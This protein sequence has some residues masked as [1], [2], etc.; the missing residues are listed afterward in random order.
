MPIMA[1]PVTIW[2]AVGAI[3]AAV[4]GLGSYLGWWEV[5]RQRPK[6]EPPPEGAHDGVLG[7]TGARDGHSDSVDERY[8]AYLLATYQYLDFKGILQLERLP[9]RLPLERVYVRLHAD[10]TLSTE[11]S[12]DPTYVAGRA[13]EK[14]ELANLLSENVARKGEAIHRASIDELLSA[15]RSIVLLGDPGSGKS[16]VLKYLALTAARHRPIGT[17]LDE[18]F[19]P[20][21]VPVAA[22]AAAIR[23][24]R[25]VPFDQYCSDYYRDVRGLPY[26]L[27]P[28]FKTAL[29]DGRALVLIDG[30]DEV[31][32]PDQRLFVV[33]RIEDFYNLHRNR[34]NRFVV[35]SR[36]LGYRDAPLSAAGVAHF[37]LGDFSRQDIEQFARNWCTAFETAIRGDTAAVKEA[38]GD[39]AAALLR[40]VVANPNVER[41]AANPLL[42]TILALI[43]RQGMELPR[44]RV[45]LYELYLKTLI[46][47]WAR[48][49]NLDGRPIGPMD[50]VEAV[51]LLAPVAYWMHET[52]PSG[53]A[54]SD[55]LIARIGGYFEEKRHRTPDDAE[56]MARQFIEDVKRYTGVLTERGQNAYG[57][58]HLTFEEYLAAREITFCGQV[59]KEKAV[60]L[61]REH[62][63][64]P[65]W[66]EV[67]R[68]AV[69]YTSIIAKEERAAGM[70]VE[71]L[72]KSGG[73]S[74]GVQNVLVAGECVRDAQI[75][76]V[77]AES[78][79]AVAKEL[80]GLVSDAGVDVRARHR[81]G[82]ILG[83]IED[84]RF[85]DHE[86]VPECVAISDMSFVM[87]TEAAS[88]DAFISEVSKVELA[89]EFDWVRHYW[90]VCLKSE[91]PQHEGRVAAFRMSRFPITHAQY[92]CFINETPGYEVPHSESER[93]KSY[94]WDKKTRA[95][96][97][98]RS[99]HP[100][101]LISWIDAAAYC[102]WL[103][104]VSGRR[105]RL[106]T[107]AEWEAAARGG[108]R[109]LY[110]WGDQ[111]IPTR[112]NTAESGANGT[113]ASGCY[114]DAVSPCGIWDC[115]GQVW[116]WTSTIWGKSWEDEEFKYPYVRDEREGTAGSHWRV[117]RGGSWD[118]VAV[119][120]RCAARGPNT[121]TF[122]SHYLGFRIVQEV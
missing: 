33:S 39:E 55:E 36:I 101:V 104:A 37:A 19:V 12:S 107:E 4:T 84:T 98:G 71:G 34:G 79:A 30:L 31:T 7:L 80:V 117:V 57:F 114:P 27:A 23:D 9:V 59:E 108:G 106:P 1:D 41:L 113:V 11:G 20:I 14:A 54:R 60:V 56:A 88:V 102:A 68:L 67:V 115:C 21:L 5:R 28:L 40:A 76:G 64:D 32:D 35:T 42:L 110:S 66:Q 121:E 2:T 69:G 63:S 53:T 85:K 47:S 13:V 91:V 73:E 16:T 17:L 6:Q 122:K 46:N 89:A 109:G 70:M 24:G 26:D 94:S 44:R 43:H 105:F 96:P 61:L 120:A 92:Q 25:P 48:A 22:Y 3:I 86:R 10:R 51:K 111:W 50:E 93:A 82:D 75:E 62:V 87:G 83:A 103:T 52:K 99:N 81:G 15:N 58:I 90:T 112:A 95:H 116:E 45:E 78:W 77:G 49:R 38:A 65:A 118:D 119:F 100:V 29:D 18:R 97:P 8:R 72:L 74:R